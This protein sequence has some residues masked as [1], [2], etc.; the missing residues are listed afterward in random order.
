VGRYLDSKYSPEVRRLG[1]KRH[2]VAF[3]CH[4]FIIDLVFRLSHRVMRC[5]FV[6][7]CGAFKRQKGGGG[8]VRME[9]WPSGEEHLLR[10]QG[11][12]VWVPESMLDNS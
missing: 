11:T 1:S 9:G 8:G 7:F 12:R 5:L 10:L 6:C 3:I 2:T 4:Y